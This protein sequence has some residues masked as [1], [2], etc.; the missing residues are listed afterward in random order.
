MCREV[1][2]GQLDDNPVNPRS[3]VGERNVSATQTLRNNDV[4]AT[5]GSPSS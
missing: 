1:I 2:R 5:G 3:T 4:E